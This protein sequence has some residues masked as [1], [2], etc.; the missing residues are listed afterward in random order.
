VKEIPLNKDELM[1]YTKEIG[2]ENLVG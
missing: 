1:V 2:I